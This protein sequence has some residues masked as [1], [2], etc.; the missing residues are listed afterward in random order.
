V[1]GTVGQGIGL[2]VGL[3]LTGGLGIAS[4]VFMHVACRSQLK[5]VFSVPLFPY[6]PAFSYLLNCFMCASLPANAYIQVSVL[7]GG[8]FHRSQRL[9]CNYF[10]SYATHFF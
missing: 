8:E 9:A 1:W 10:Y 7:L 5:P 4:A 6:V 3:C 2:I